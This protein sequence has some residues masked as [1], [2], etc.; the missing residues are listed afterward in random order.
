MAYNY[1]KSYLYAHRAVV[2]KLIQSAD[3]RLTLSMVFD[4]PDDAQKYRLKISN[5]L[6]S[7]ARNEPTKAYVRNIV[8]TRLEYTKDGRWELLIGP[9]DGPIRGRKP[10][11][12]EV[13]SL[14][15]SGTAELTESPEDWSAFMLALYTAC[16]SGHKRISFPKPEQEVEKFAVYMNRM[17]APAWEVAETSPRVILHRIA[18][19]KASELPLFTQKEDKDGGSETT[20]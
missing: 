4:L 9:V 17:L 6:A 5:L 20:Q 11:V 14:A 16:N 18:E 15:R 19:F 3:E 13:P 7:L 2:A 10:E 12:I 1:S 8:R